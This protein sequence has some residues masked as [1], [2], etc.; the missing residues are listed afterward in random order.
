MIETL[1]FAKRSK[2]FKLPLT[3]N[4][5]GKYEGAIP[6]GVT[7]VRLTIRGGDGGKGGS[8]TS[9]P[10]YYPGFAGTP[11]V[12]EVSV[13]PGE[14]LTINVGAAGWPGYDHYMNPGRG[15]DGESSSVY[16]G[17]TLIASANGGSGAGCFQHG[18]G[19]NRDGLV[20]IEAIG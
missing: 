16:N 3:L 1:L 10:T 14:S 13:R 4:K 6:S 18:D 17:A 5:A 19:S 15:T 20:V 11:T 9:R 7:K 12:V 8:L 2:A